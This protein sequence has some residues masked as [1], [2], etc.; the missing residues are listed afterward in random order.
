MLKVLPLTAGLSVILAMTPVSSVGWPSK[1]H[2]VEFTPSQSGN[3]VFLDVNSIHKKKGTNEVTYKVRNTYSKATS[4]GAVR[5]NAVYTAYCSFNAQRLK[6]FT[7]YNISNRIVESLKNSQ[8]PL[9]QVSVG[10]L[11][12][13]AFKYVCSR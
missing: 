13:S 1:A 9:E 2:W 12:Y 10:S 5:S 3:R 4:N 7:A 6:D 11:N 8:S